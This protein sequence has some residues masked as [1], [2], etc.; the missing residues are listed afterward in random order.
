VRQTVYQ[1][2]FAQEGR[3]LAP[4]IDDGDIRTMVGQWCIFDT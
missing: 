4:T 3:A 2:R 1:Q